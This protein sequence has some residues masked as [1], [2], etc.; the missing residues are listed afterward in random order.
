MLRMAIQW[1]LSQ[2]VDDG[3]APGRFL[4][5]ILRHDVV[6]RQYYEN[7]LRLE[8]RLRHDAVSLLEEA[9]RSPRKKPLRLL[10]RSTARRIRDI[11]H[12]RSVRKSFFIMALSMVFVF[13]A[14]AFYSAL[15][16]PIDG[17]ND[18]HAASLSEGGSAPD[19]RILSDPIINDELIRLCRQSP[20]ESGPFFTD[21][22]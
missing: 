21:P 13:V 14:G 8:G 7:L 10:D 9:A 5:F 1:W 12:W 2:K 17:P 11:L 15:I 16:F 3:V 20:N 4:S 6:S 19:T 18:V 22:L